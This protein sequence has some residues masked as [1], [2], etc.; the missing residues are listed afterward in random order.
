[1]DVKIFRVEGRFRMGDEFNKFVKE[2]RAVKKEHAIEKIYSELGS[3]HKVKRFHIIIE[4]VKEIRPEEVKD[5]IVR[6]L[7]GLE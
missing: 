3:K 4:R 5:P 1:M 2:I 7:S 6:Y